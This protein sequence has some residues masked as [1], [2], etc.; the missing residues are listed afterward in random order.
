MD[1]C[2]RRNRK[3]E[4]ESVC[5]CGMHVGTKCPTPSQVW[6]PSRQEKESIAGTAGYSFSSISQT[7]TAAQR[8]ST[9]PIKNLEIQ[10]GEIEEMILKEVPSAAEGNVSNARRSGCLQLVGTQSYIHLKA[11]SREPDWHRLFSFS[12]SFP[13]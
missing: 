7:T 9:K 11:Y 6:T 4:R 1:E 12:L 2:L 5:V 3:R 13:L 8:I 10:T